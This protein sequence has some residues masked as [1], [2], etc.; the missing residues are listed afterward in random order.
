MSLRLLVTAL[1][2]LA[3][4]AAAPALAVG[5][6]A[7]PAPAAMPAGKTTP[8]PAPAPQ[9]PAPSKADICPTAGYSCSTYFEQV[10][11]LSPAEAAAVAARAPPAQL[12][13][14]AAPWDKVE[15]CPTTSLKGRTAS[16]IEAQVGC[17]AAREGQRERE[18]GWRGRARRGER[19]SRAQCAL[20]PFFDLPLS[21]SFT[22]P[23]C[24]CVRVH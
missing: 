7:A 10:V 18:S 24:V 20:P 8:T 22:H 15:P 9:K 6:D 13:N 19:R 5:A 11:A 4:L 16:Q 12:S 2:V 3:A 1:A 14:G 21:L 23:V 17:R